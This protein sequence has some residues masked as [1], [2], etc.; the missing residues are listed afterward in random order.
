MGL[1]AYNLG[2]FGLGFGG[3][4]RP[5]RLHLSFAGQQGPE[6]GNRGKDH[7]AVGEA[8]VHELICQ[9]LPHLATKALKGSLE[10]PARVL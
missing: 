4:V 3:C 7:A 6:K 8:S 1:R 2:L 5:C 9:S 10:V